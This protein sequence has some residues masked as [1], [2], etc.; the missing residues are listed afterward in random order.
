MY[1]ILASFEENL[2][3][4]RVYAD[5]KKHVQVGGNFSALSSVCRLQ[6]PGHERQDLTHCCLY[7]LIESLVI[8]GGD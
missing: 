1:S 2:N 7:S 4:K 3:N 8:T 5:L 6:S